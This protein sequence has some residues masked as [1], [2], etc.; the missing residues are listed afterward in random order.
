VGLDICNL[1]AYNT[2]IMISIK[3]SF[4]KTPARLAISEFLLNANTPVDVEQIVQYLRSQKLETNKVTVYRTL[5]ALF[6]NQIID[7]VEFREGKYRYEFKKN[8][9]HHLICTN[10]GNVQDVEADEVEKL[11]RE[12]Q[13]D[14]NFKVKSHSLEF[15]G[16]CSDC[17]K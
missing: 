17:Q 1:V 15:F 11:E 3:S 12:I 2:S 14:K 6:N 5:D 8:H 9:H 16:I 7:R 13:K 10:C 4:K